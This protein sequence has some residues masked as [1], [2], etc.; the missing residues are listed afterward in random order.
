MRISVVASCFNNENNIAEFLNVTRTAL[1]QL[2]HDF[3]IIVVDDGSSDASWQIL[4]SFSAQD[5][6]FRG[7]RL[8]R[9]FGQHPA[10]LAG[11]D[12]SSGDVTV[13][14]DSDMDDDPRLIQT[15]VQPIILNEVDIVLTRSFDTGRQHV[16][17][18]LFHK[19]VQNSTQSPHSLGVGTYR[20]FNARVTRSLREYRD[21]ST[22][23]GPLSTQI[24]FRQMVLQVPHDGTPRRGSN[25][26]FKMRLR[27]AWPVLLNEVGL[28][29]K[30]VLT[31]VT[32]MVAAVLLLGLIA[33]GRFLG[34]GGDPSSTTSLVFLVLTINQ[35][36]LGVGIAIISLYVRTI[37]R[38]TLRRPRFHIAD[39][40]AVRDQ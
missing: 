15:L 1:E 6:R 7:I 2:G 33:V 20:A 39:D 35:V 34:G 5:G 11:L 27:L 18:R 17:S 4:T 28:P 12:A 38:E 13:L 30:L 16:S 24:G 40:T 36:L 37:L 3:E 23:Y 31:A 32:F 10:I 26:D 14:I 19:L 9:N 25:Y 22:L 29:L 8:S 21:H